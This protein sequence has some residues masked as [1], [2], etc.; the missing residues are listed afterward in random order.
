[1]TL[2]Q[3]ISIQN[4]KSVKPDYLWKISQLRTSVFNR[5][6]WHI[7]AY[8]TVLGIM[9]LSVASLGFLYMHYSGQKLAQVFQKNTVLKQE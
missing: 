1:M 8:T 2:A 3:N 9:L 7:N 5:L 6:W 4:N